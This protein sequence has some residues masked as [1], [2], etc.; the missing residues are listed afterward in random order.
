LRK[1]QTLSAQRKSDWALRDISP[2]T[3]ATRQ[4]QRGEAFEAKEWAEDWYFGLKDKGRR[5]EPLAEKTFK[6]VVDQFIA[7]YEV[8]TD[9]E[10]NARWVRDHYRRVKAYL[11]PL[12]GKMAR[13]REAVGHA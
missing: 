9:G 10:R 4:Q 7:E 3:K 8:L 2:R 1:G 12:F 11:A 13:F 5:G 6:D